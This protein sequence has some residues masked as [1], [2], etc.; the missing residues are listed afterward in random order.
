M[1]LAFAFHS[2][3]AELDLSIKSYFDSTPVSL[4]S[5]L[6]FLKTLKS[7]CISKEYLLDDL[8]SIWRKRYINFLSN[9]LEKEHDN[10]IRN[11]VTI[12]IRQVRQISVYCVSSINR[13]R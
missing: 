13:C 11:R 6:G 9:F 5:Y 12:L 8:K 3:S 4:W 10:D 7:Y 1:Y 2:M